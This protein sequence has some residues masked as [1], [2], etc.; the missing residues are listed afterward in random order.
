MIN[1]CGVCRNG[2]STIEKN[3]YKCKYVTKEEIVSVVKCDRLGVVLIKAKEV[4]IL[5]YG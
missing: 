4:N 1:G 5:P 3:I 2:Q